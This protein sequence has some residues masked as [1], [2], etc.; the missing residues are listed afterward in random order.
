[1]GGKFSNR[2]LIG[3]Y[4][5]FTFFYYAI[6][7]LEIEPFVSYSDVTGLVGNLLAFPLFWRGIRNCPEDFSQPLTDPVYLRPAVFVEPRIP[8]QVG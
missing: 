8:R 6:L 5:V 3:S 7:G 4:L 1:M 2:A